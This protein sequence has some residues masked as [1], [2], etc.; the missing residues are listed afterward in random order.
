MQEKRESIQRRQGSLSVTRFPGKNGIELIEATA[1][2][3]SLP[4][5]FHSVYCIG[6]IREGA[7]RCFYRGSHHVFG[8]GQLFIIPPGESH[9]CE[10]FESLPYSYS[11]FCIDPREWE[12]SLQLL[13]EGTGQQLLRQRT[14]VISTPVFEDNRLFVLLMALAETLR[15]G[16]DGSRQL[17]A[18]SLYAEAMVRLHTTASLEPALAPTP[19]SSG[20]IGEQDRSAV[21]AVKEYLQ[22]HADDF[23]KDE[24]S[25]VS[26]EDLSRIT[27]LSVY[28]LNRLFSREVGMPPHAYHTQLRIR[29]AKQKLAQG[30]TPLEAALETGFYDQSHFHRCFVK[31]VG[32]TPARYAASRRGTVL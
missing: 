20:G 13:G 25:N 26:G 17:A 15:N 31:L 12:E 11:M 21:Q 5:H 27:G 4:R 7:R 10:S 14:A 24:S 22:A 8:A 19:V 9:T 30:K 29:Q 3:H 28:Y 18:D 2:R 1:I 16:H 23:S 6:L 32:M